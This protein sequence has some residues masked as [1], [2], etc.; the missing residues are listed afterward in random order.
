MT[1]FLRL[2][3]SH[4]GDDLT[5]GARLTPNQAKEALFKSHHPEITSFFTRD[6][7]TKILPRFHLEISLSVNHIHGRSNDMGQRHHPR[8]GLCSGRGGSTEISITNAAPISARGL[9]GRRLIPKTRGSKTCVSAHL[10]VS[11]RN[12]VNSNQATDL[13]R[14]M[15]TK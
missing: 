9:S 1:S 13:L 6:R 8:T 2:T 7:I 4:L 3:I 14:M 10:T 5:Y 12:S 11:I 15:Q